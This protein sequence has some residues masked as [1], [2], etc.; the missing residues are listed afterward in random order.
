MRIS[1]ETAVALLFV[2]LLGIVAAY[3]LYT[4]GYGSKLQSVKDVPVN[5]I[6]GS[7]SSIDSLHMEVVRNPIPG[8]KPA[9]PVSVTILLNS[10][11][12]YFLLEP[13]EGIY[14]DPDIPLSLSPKSDKQEEPKFP[15][16][17]TGIPGSASDVHVESFVG[18]IV[19]EDA[20]KT[21][22]LTALKVMLFPDNFVGD[23][24]VLKAAGTGE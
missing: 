11:T 13:V 4:S 10:K 18:I 24:R 3:A 19:A 5:E 22:Q 17:F 21:V 12:E 6:L 1:K 20:R 23:E 15:P 16:P 14:Y 7:V 8:E 2:A 9:E